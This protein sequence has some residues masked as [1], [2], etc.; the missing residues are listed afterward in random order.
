MNFGINDIKELTASMAEYPAMDYS[1]YAFS[2]LKRRLSYLFTRLNIRR[3]DQFIEMLQQPDFR[4]KILFHMGVDTTEMFRDPAFWRTLRD[5]ILGHLPAD[6][7]NIWLPVVA[8]GEEMFSLA[9]LLHE[10]NLSQKYKIIG[11]TPSAEQCA[12]IQDGKLN[13]RHDD[14]NQTNYK[15]LEDKNAYQEY[16]ERHNGFCLL[17]ERFR[18][19]IDCRHASFPGLMPSEDA[20]GLILF[21]NV[22]IYYNLKLTQM[23]FT[24]IIDKL[25]PGGYLV[26][27][28][29]EQLP[30]AIL[31]ALIE[32]DATEKIYRKPG[33]KH[34]S[35]HA[36][37]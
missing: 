16:I 5:K 4:E 17:N 30:A 22:S 18:R 36:G 23:V 32:V 19:N 34:N 2:F 28:T 11:Q 26:I 8:S 6:C 21:R 13:A 3:K 37:Y 31:E 25:M 10:N 15:R 9:I 20:I 14:V 7:E 33:L 1:N 24:Q 29:K 27:G 35:N 12:Y